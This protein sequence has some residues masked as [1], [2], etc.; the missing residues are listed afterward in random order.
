M[1]ARGKHPPVWRSIFAP[2][3]FSGQFPKDWRQSG[4]I[5]VA[6]TVEGRSTE[7]QRTDARKKI[8]KYFDTIPDM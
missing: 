6:C 1:M 2:R 4:P 5:L 8:K 3:L 7:I